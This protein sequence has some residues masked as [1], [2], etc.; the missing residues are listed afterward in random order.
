MVLK[1]KQRQENAEEINYW[2]HGTN[3][4]GA[5]AKRK[6]G[7]NLKKGQTERDFSNGQGF[8][9]TPC[10]TTVNNWA[11]QKKGISAILCF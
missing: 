5:T 6:P 8:Y 3:R 7:I 10:P 4:R 9:L 11:I 2:Y 1:S